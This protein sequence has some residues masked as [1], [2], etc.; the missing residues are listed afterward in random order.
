MKH[1]TSA[2]LIIPAIMLALVLAACSPPS[3]R[4]GDTAIQN[5]TIIDDIRSPRSR[6]F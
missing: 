2:I 6:D 1:G 5:G 4:T 3:G